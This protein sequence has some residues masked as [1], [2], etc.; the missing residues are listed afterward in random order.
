MKDF[1]GLDKQSVDDLYSAPAM[2]NFQ[3]LS[4]DKEALCD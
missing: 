4:E 3:I 2:I 1:T